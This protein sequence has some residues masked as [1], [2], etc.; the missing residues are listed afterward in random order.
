MPHKQWRAFRPDA[1]SGEVVQFPTV[2]NDG[3]SA[4]DD[5][6]FA[7]LVAKEQLKTRVRQAAATAEATRLWRSPLRG[8]D[9]GPLSELQARPRTSPRYLVD[10]LMGWGHNV[11]VAAQYKTGKTTLAGNLAQALTDELPFLGRT[12]RLPAEAGVAWW[13]AEMENDDLED[14]LQRIGFQSPERLHV[15]HLRGLPVSLLSDVGQDWAIAMLR[16]ANAAVWIIDSWRRL[17][18]WA[19]VDENRNDEVE[20]LLARIDEIK[21]AAGVQAVV[22]LAHTG[23]ATQEA[24]S[25]H[26][27]GAT[28][29]DDWCDARWVL[30]RRGAA[31]FMY[32]EGR[33]VVLAETALTFDSGSNRIALGEGDRHTAVDAGLMARVVDCVAVTPGQATYKIKEA[34][35]ISSKNGRDGVEPALRIA[36]RDEVLH[37]RDKPNGARGRNWYLGSRPKEHP[38]TCDWALS[39]LTV[40][41]KPEAP[42]PIPPSSPDVPPG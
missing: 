41:G 32:A 40:K 9:F 2:E 16:E 27:R 30:V 7:E 18:A 24:G 4:A 19:G 22:L 23:R 8:T 26:A 10:G 1:P 15:A 20:P 34:L 36:E 35:G 6:Q 13:N 38:C 29:L 14:E 37:H 28:A 12:T 31:R 3:R 39:A 42:A 17:C 21:A 11:V 5:A 33:R 25:E